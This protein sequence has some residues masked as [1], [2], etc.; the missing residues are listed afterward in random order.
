MVMLEVYSMAD[1]EQLPRNKCVF[2]FLSSH[3]I[4][5]HLI[6]SH[7]I[8][9]NLISSHL[10]SSHL[11]SSH[12]IIQSNPIPCN[13]DGTFQSR[14]T[15]VPPSTCRLVYRE[16]PRPIWMCSRTAFHRVQMLQTSKTLTSKQQM[17]RRRSQSGGSIGERKWCARLGLICCWFQVSVCVIYRP[18]IYK[19]GSGSQQ[20][21]PWCAP[22]LKW[23][24]CVTS[25][26]INCITSGMGWDGM[27]WFDLIWFDL[28]GL[29]WIGCR[30]CVWCV[31]T[32]H[33]TGKRLLRSVREEDYG[34][35]RSVHCTRRSMDC[36]GICIAMSYCHT[37]AWT[38]LCVRIQE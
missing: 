27:G 24:T 33:G 8:S 29:D 11:I 2:Y 3:P 21:H 36:E 7:L 26:Y 25:I 12:L 17:C 22:T 19:R 1:I 20:T 14:L 28:M 5:S 34:L 37:I 31:W 9:S 30:C 23:Q 13:T 10:I 15:R 32:S 6:S 4:S 18:E 16:R 35:W 38:R